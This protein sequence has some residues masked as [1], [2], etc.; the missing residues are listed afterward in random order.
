MK[1][2]TLNLAV[3]L[4]ILRNIGKYMIMLRIVFSRPE[5]WSVFRVRL[6][7]EIQRIGINSIPIVGVMSV[8]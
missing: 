8:F 7:E 2:N 4:I 1:K 6:F 3:V 5:K